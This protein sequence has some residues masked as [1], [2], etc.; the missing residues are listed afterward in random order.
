MNI[1]IFHVYV[2]GASGNGKQL[3]KL[4]DEACK[5]CL[6]EGGYRI[7][8]IDILKKPQLA[9]KHKVLATPTISRT[10][11]GPEKRIIGKLNNEQAVTAIKFLTEDLLI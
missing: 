7:E 8:I 3:L 5:V 4:Y 6:K 11:P 2:A 9:E 10:D 1:I